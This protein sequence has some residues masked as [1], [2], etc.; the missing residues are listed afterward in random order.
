M[1]MVEENPLGPVQLKVGFG[2]GDEPFRVIVGVLQPIVPPVAFA[3]GGVLFRLTVADAV[4]VQLLVGL[5][6]VTV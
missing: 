1:A 3:P 6:T 5:V 4:E 2:A